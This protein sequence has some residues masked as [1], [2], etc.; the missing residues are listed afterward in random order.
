MSEAAILTERMPRLNPGPG[1]RHPPDVRPAAGF[2][3]ALTAA[4]AV[5]GCAS[6]PKPTA[7][8]VRASTLVNE[9]EKDQAQRYAAVDLQRARDELSGAQTADSDGKYD[10]ARTL[11]EKA[12]ADADL[13]SARATSGKARE[14]AHEVHR[15]L[16]SLRQ[17]VHESPAPSGT[18]GPGQ[19][20]P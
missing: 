18:T 15:S 14:S 16:D 4:L 2:I 1:V 13:A 11:A 17:Q 3:V 20:Q 9:A 6:G 12:S 10:R 8:L 7:E 19:D 5:G